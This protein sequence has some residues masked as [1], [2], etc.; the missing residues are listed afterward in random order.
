[1]R[2]PQTS[3]S[4]FEAMYRQNHDPWQFARSESELERYRAILQALAGRRYSAAFEPAC[5][6]GVLTAQL[7]ALA[8]QVVSIDISPTA[9][10]LARE[11]CASLSNVE[12]H[13]MSITEAANVLLSR[14]HF[15]LLVLSEI[16]YYFDREA[17]SNVLRSLLDRVEPGCV[18]LTSHW[19]G[20]SEDHYIDGDEVHQVVA[21]NGR[22]YLEHAE[23]HESFRLD[24][25]MYR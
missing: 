15:D 9:V 2:T 8:D 25:W 3:P 16:G 17:W 4:F 21:A 5:S 6:I 24:R 20:Y 14:V 7:A 13:C 19:L 23:R 1:M 18:V 12:I 22:L 11:R 10:E